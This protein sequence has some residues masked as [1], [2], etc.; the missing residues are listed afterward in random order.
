MQVFFPFADLEPGSFVDGVVDAED[1]GYGFDGGLVALFQH[2][3]V[4]LL[5]G[6]VHPEIGV[7]G[8]V[9]WGWCGII[10]WF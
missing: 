2:G 9:C 6:G 1:G 10:V 5:F 7:G 8:L 3:I 4:E